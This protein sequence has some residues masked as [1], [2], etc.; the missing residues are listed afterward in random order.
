MDLPAA[1]NS[2]TLIKIISIIDNFTELWGRSIT[3]LTLLMMA[4]TF[5]VVLLRY[6][7]NLGSIALQ[8]SVMYLHATV[9]MAASAYALK[10]DGHVRV[11]I[12]YRN[13]SRTRK[14][15]INLLGTLLLLWPVCGF[16]GWISL[17][18][19]VASWKILEDSPEAGGIPAIFLLK[20]LI[21][22]LV[23]TLALQGLG[24]FLRS[25]TV[26]MDLPGSESFHANVS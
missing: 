13:F 8:E 17:D 3:W 5:L 26:I 7:A 6:V 2:Q 16:I 23:I 20:S 24:E 4:I 15:W 10:H 11:D 9:F 19:V 1:M 22:I 18:Y 21:P 12:F 25:L 14:A